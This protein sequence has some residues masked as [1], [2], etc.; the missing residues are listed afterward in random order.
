ML[1]RYPSAIRPFYTMACPDDG[2]YSNSFDI[3]MRG[4]EIISG[5]QRIHDPVMLAARAA[6]C[7]IEV[8]TIQ[9][10][11]DSFKLGAS[12]HGGCGVGLERVVMLFLGLN[13]IR[14]TS[15]FPRDPKRLT[16]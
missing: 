5:A 7:G 13:N 12:P 16:P 10:Y 1:H 4:E 2:D 8:G 11:I 9:S 14:K 3:F 6:E 15:M